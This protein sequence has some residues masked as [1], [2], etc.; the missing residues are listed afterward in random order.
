MSRIPDL[1]FWKLLGSGV[2]EGFTPL[3]NFGVYGVLTVWPSLDAAKKNIAKLK[4]FE[5]YRRKSSED[6]TVFLNTVS[7]RG[8][9]SGTAPFTLEETPV[10][11]KQSSIVAL[12]RATIRPK[13]LLQ[14]WRRVPDISSMIGQ[15]KNVQMKIG[16]GEV[17][18]L[19]QIT[20]SIWPDT[21]AMAEFARNNGPHSAAI[22]AVR[23]GNWFS[24]ELY[25]RFKIVEEI[26]DWSDSKRERMT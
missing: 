4:V 19:H 23:D 6:W 20:F 7:A 1:S 17:P 15:D 12:T 16:L 14:F 9:W 24:E 25:A 18:W 3:P 2:G 22:K 8:E 13:V 26:G 11:A 21:E 5:L 10:S